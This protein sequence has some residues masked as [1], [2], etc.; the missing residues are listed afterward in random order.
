M[1][2]SRLFRSLSLPDTQ[3]HMPQIAN[4]VEVS[5]VNVQL[6]DRKGVGASTAVVTINQSDEKSPGGWASRLP[7]SWRLGEAWSSEVSAPSGS[8]N[9]LSM[10]VASDDNLD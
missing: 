6:L 10:A 8:G 9:I 2:R 5:V 7:M 3:T 4:Q 1:L